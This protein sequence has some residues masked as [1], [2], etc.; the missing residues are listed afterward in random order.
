ML[1]KY[2]PWPKKILLILEIIGQY[3]SSSFHDSICLGKRDIWQWHPSYPDKH[4]FARHKQLVSEPLTFF[5]KSR[6]SIFGDVLQRLLRDERGFVIKWRLA[7]FVQYVAFPFV[8][9]CVLPTPEYFLG[10]TAEVAIGI[11][12]GNRAPGVH[13]SD[14]TNVPNR[15]CDHLTLELNF[16][17]DGSECQTILRNVRLYWEI[18]RAQFFDTT[19]KVTKPREGLKNTMGIRFLW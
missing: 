8:R 4:L 9:A 11:L 12:G 3:N 10:T 19:M 14:F 6:C 16:I 17:K 1:M 7:L 5:G 18:V 13:Y 2:L 15:D